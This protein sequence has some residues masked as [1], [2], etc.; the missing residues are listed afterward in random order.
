MLREVQSYCQPPAFREDT[1]RACLAGTTKVEPPEGKMSMRHVIAHALVAVAHLRGPLDADAL[2]EAIRE[3]A[4]RSLELSTAI[5]A[6]KSRRREAAIL[7]ALRNT[8]V[9][10]W[11]N[12]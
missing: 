4:P 3:A 11:L 8:N 7:N 6:F 12:R 10:T 1:L 5:L 2:A 9:V